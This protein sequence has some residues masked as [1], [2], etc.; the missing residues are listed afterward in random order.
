MNVTVIDLDK[1]IKTASEDKYRAYFQKEL[2][3]IQ[4]P[5]GTIISYDDGYHEI[6]FDKDIDIEMSAVLNDE[7]VHTMPQYHA[8]EKLS[9]MLDSEACTE[10]KLIQFI[11]PLTSGI[12]DQINMLN[13]INMIKERIKD[14][15]LNPKDFE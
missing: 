11:K 5:K 7:E 13:H 6:D 15:G 9:V 10:K 4:G 2:G 1:Y 3:I 12:E 8:T 14:I